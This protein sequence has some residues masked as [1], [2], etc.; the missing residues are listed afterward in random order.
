MQNVG[1][2]TLGN[3]S[4]KESTCKSSCCWKNMEVSALVG[5]PIPNC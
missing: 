4:D 3:L 5:K 1:V 2:S